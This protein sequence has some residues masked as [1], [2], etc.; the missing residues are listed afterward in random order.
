MAN[1]LGVLDGAFGDFFCEGRVADGGGVSGGIGKVDGI[2]GG[3][4]VEVSITPVEADGVKELLKQDDW[5]RLIYVKSDEE[6][7]TVS[8]RHVD[9]GMVGLMLV[10]FE[11]EENVSFVNV[12]GDLNLATLMKLVKEFDDASIEDMLEELE[13]VEG[14]EIDHN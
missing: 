13:G 5:K 14:I 11:A 8:T 9:G 10:V 2:V 7:V 6:T 4:A 3:V 12:V 1:F